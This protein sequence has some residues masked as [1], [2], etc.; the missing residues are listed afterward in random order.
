MNTKNLYL[1]PAI[2][3]GIFLW[4]ANA[5]GPG[6]VQGIDRTGSPL[7][8]GSCGECH[9]GGNFSPV[10]AAELL[11]GGAPVSQYEPDKSYILRVRIAA[12]SGTPARYGFQAVALSGTGNVTAGSWGTAPAGFK[13]I[14]IQGREYV[15]HNTPRQSNTLEMP[16][17]APAAATGSIRFY[18]AGIAANN[19]ADSSGDSPAQLAEALVIAPL[20][21][22]V[23]EIT[24]SRLQI[25]VLGNPVENE[26]RLNLHSPESG[27]CHFVL[28]SLNGKIIWR[29]SQKIQSG[30]NALQ[31]D[32]NNLPQGVY[33]L[34]ARHSSFGATAKIVR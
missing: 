21:S 12:G 9:S 32:T 17:T 14:S 30:E 8:P 6:T 2:G 4:I 23:D 26:L 29:Q 25:K 19:N 10:I 28:T 7:S 22:S 5:A 13:K 34:Q 24:N 33:L 18:S 1:L 3:L 20:V 15:E 11:D 16:W 31:F 27:I